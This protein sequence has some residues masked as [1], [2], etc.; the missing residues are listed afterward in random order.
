MKVNLCRSTLLVVTFV[1]TLCGGKHLHGEPYGL[2]ASSYLG[3]SGSDDAVRGAVI[4]ADGT[5]CLAANLADGNPAAPRQDSL[6]SGGPGAVVRLSAD[7]RALLS[8]TRLAGTVRDLAHDEAGNLYVAAGTDG[9][10][11]LDPTAQTVLWQHLAGELVTRVDAAADGH[12]VALIGGSTSSNTPG[13]GEV[14]LFAND[15]GGTQMNRFN[16]GWHA[17]DVCIDGRTQTIAQAG[18]YNDMVYNGPYS[19]SYNGRTTTPVDVPYVLGF[20][21]DYDAMGGIGRKWELH[22]WNGGPW[23]DKANRIPNPEFI[24][25]PFSTAESNLY[26]QA[27]ADALSADTGHDYDY[28]VGM[29]KSFTN[30]M[31]DTRAYRVSMGADG[32]LYVGYEADGGNTPLR[33]DPQDLTVSAPWTSSDGFFDSF[34]ATSTVPKVVVSRHALTST[35][36]QW[37][38]TFG[39]TSRKSERTDGTSDNTIHMEDG[40]LEA[41]AQGRVYLG[42]Q[43]YFGFYLPDHP[44]ADF[45]IP[46]PGEVSFDPFSDA[47]LGGACLMVMSPDF[48]TREYTTR[49]GG[50]GVHA[51]ATRLL[52]ENETATIVW[53]GQHSALDASIS[54]LHTVAAIQPA[55]TGD[56][57]ADEGFFAVVEGERATIRAVAEAQLVQTNPAVLELDGRASFSDQGDLAS[58]HWEAVNTGSFLFAGAHGRIQLP[59]GAYR[60]RL[61]VKDL[62]GNQHADTFEILIP[63]AN[64]TAPPRFETVPADLAMRGISYSTTFSSSS[65]EGVPTLTMTGPIPGGLSFVDNGD[66]TATLAGTPTETGNFRLEVAAQAGGVASRQVLLLRVWE[67]GLGGVLIDDD[68]STNTQNQWSFASDSSIDGKPSEAWKAE[69]VENY[70]GSGVLLSYAATTDRDSRQSSLHYREFTWPE[71]LSDAALTLDGVYGG[72][73]GGSANVAVR[74]EGPS[75][76]AWAISDQSVDTGTT[77]VET[78]Y[79]LPTFTWRTLDISNLNAGGGPAV[80]AGEILPAV[81]AA[82]IAGIDASGSYIGFRTLQIDGVHLESFHQP[83]ADHPP[84]F[85]GT[86]PATAVIGQ[87]FSFAP[88]ASDPEGTAVSLSTETALPAWLQF[89]GTTFSGTPGAADQG[90][91]EIRLRAEDATGQTAWLSFFLQVVP[92]PVHAAFSADPVFGEAPLEVSVDAAASSGG[93]G[94]QSYEWDFGD[95]NSATGVA[96][97]HVYSTAGTYTLR[98][99]ATGTNGQT[100]SAER[101]VIV[102]APGEGADALWQSFQNNPDNHGHV[103]DNSYAGY[104]YGNHPIPDR[105]VVVDVTDPEFGAVA[106]PGVDNTAAIQAAIDFAG[107][108][109]GGA[110]FIPAGSYEIHGMLFITRSGVVLRGA[111]KGQTILD[112]KTPLEDLITFRGTSGGF[113][114][115]AGQIWISPDDIFNAEERGTINYTADA[116]LNGDPHEWEYHRPGPV[117]AEP[118]GEYERGDRRITVDDASAIQPGSRV[119]M[120]WRHDNADTLLK[121]I[122]AFDQ[123]DD[124]SDANWRRG[125]TG[126][127]DGDNYDSRW[128]QPGDYNRYQWLVEVAQVEGNVLVLRQPLRLPVR[129]AYAVDFREVRDLIVGSGVEDLSLKGYNEVV[130]VDDNGDPLPEWRYQF[131]DGWNGVYLLRAVDCWVRN[132]ETIDMHVSVASSSVK[133]CTFRDI[134]ILN[135]TNRSVHNLVNVRTESSDVLVEGVTFTP[136]TTEGTFYGHMGFSIEWLSSGVV[137]RDSTIGTGNPDYH[138]GLAFDFIMTDVHWSAN[139]AAPGGN[140]KAGPYVGRRSVHWNVS[141]DEGQWINRPLAHPAGAMVGV[142]APRQTSAN[143]L[144]GIAYGDKNCLIVDEGLTPAVTDLYL[145]QRAERRQSRT[146]ASVTIVSPADK[147]FLPAGPDPLGFTIHTA[148]FAGSV[149]EEVRLF[150]NGV[151]VATGSTADWSPSIPNPGT[152]AHTY[153]VEATLAD[154]TIV[155]GNAIR[156]HVGL[157]WRAVDDRDPAITYNGWVAEDPATMPILHDSYTY[158]TGEA[159]NDTVSRTS[160]YSNPNGQIDYVFEGS[161]ALVRYPAIVMDGSK[162]YVSTWVDIY[163]NDLDTPVASRPLYFH[164]NS[165]SHR[166]VLYDTGYLPQGQ[167]AIRVVVRPENG[168]ENVGHVLFDGFEVLQDASSSA[169]TYY[170]LTVTACTGGTAGGGGIYAEGELA[171]ITAS[172]DTGYR[173]VEWTGSGITDTTAAATT[174]LMDVA[175]T[176]TAVFE[177]DTIPQY[178]LT[179]T[180]GPGGSVSGSGNYNELTHVTIS[181]MP[182]PGY[183]FVGWT[184]GNPLDSQSAHTSVFMDASQSIQA[185][186]E[187][188]PAT[189][190][191]VL[192]GYRFSDRLSGEDLA[193]RAVSR[194]TG[195]AAATE[196]SLHGLSEDS[197][198]G[199]VLAVTSAASSAS[200]YLEFTVQAP[201]GTFDFETPGSSLRFDGK[202]WNGDGTL[203]EDY[204]RVE[205]LTNGT[206]TVVGEAGIDDNPVFTLAGH[207]LSGDSSLTVRIYVVRQDSWNDASVDNLQLSGAVLKPSGYQ[208]WADDHALPADQRGEADNPDHDALSNLE[209]Y[210]LDSDPGSPTSLAFFRMVR[211]P[212]NSL[213]AEVLLGPERTDITWQFESSP[214]MAPGS[215]TTVDPQ[216]D[217]SV[218]W[219]TSGDKRLVRYPVSGPEKEFLRIAIQRQ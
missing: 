120:T 143:I 207:G 33:W 151:L 115:W 138:R 77:P 5:I 134:D 101:E 191:T 111:G 180:A 178:T 194:L 167:H 20:P 58:W 176:V 216:S 199:G 31:A 170:P 92:A 90:V 38:A 141:A 212:D 174:V 76:P 24:N 46:R 149:L 93:G 36:I 112:F 19:R 65:P 137:F 79:A 168:V 209:E 142:R 166:R 132:I 82:G 78:T 140:G 95:G 56:P 156:L 208:T 61:T 69:G 172:P 99:T 188:V 11:K 85:S 192:A 72:R 86:L 135:P 165:V 73:A 162:Y 44:Y 148:L 10:I 26:T 49:L 108:N 152:G 50:G 88:N 91:F 2:A 177:E 103:P 187:P 51:L 15:A 198:R 96:T 29:P 18:W 160:N 7:G 67:G 57:N 197:D 204:F 210:L 124:T 71:D 52:P 97:S 47:Y 130:T 68:F 219:S 64:G 119:L 1:I 55:A 94:I 195:D 30:N 129:E 154:G 43:S 48:R 147:G 102:H 32:K 104:G 116:I 75:G 183:Q 217:P 14:V 139:T 17:L 186:F 21:Y 157:L 80:S 206:T 109:G 150:E 9:I 121:E 182:D 122:A 13:R 145:Q 66:G 87:P 193:E 211:D 27:E 202:K 34:H 181:A 70:E 25:Y 196:V 62:P 185:S 164:A 200:D 184:G 158:T 126:V 125:F 144:Q 136:P 171:S 22:N 189:A 110:V 218:I 60:I 169:T 123:W 28:L 131:S 127:H 74:Y 118:L 8:V 3:G 146:P 42:M 100:A 175:K 81:T 45:T 98:L 153:R 133:N 163:L 41:D 213:H 39:F 83:V 205:I 59:P 63:A 6:L 84:E 117:I 40:A 190:A 12:S 106:S 203:P 23:L 113:S 53:G 215:W 107:A 155:Y 89:D 4:Q 159:I 114:W 37:E 214:T 201:V 54:P 173:F 161:R 179:L 105:P 16:T 128:L 35:S